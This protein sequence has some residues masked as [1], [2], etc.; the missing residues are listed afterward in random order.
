MRAR[1][2]LRRL[3]PVALM[4]VCLLPALTVAG[5]GAGLLLLSPALLLALPLLAGRYV[6]ERGLVRLA[7][8]AR[9]R[10]RRLRPARVPRPWPRAVAVRGGRL[11][12][13]ALAER[14]PPRLLV[15]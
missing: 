2:H 7:R 12:A 5:F 3:L 8:R 13:A 6:G 10:L 15:A 14:G 11:I 4:G 1:T 9:P